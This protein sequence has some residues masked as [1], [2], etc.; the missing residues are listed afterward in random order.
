MT[1]ATLGAMPRVLMG[2]TTTGQG[3]PP[4]DQAPTGRGHPALEAVSEATKGS[5]ATKCPRKGRAHRSVQYYAVG[6]YVGQVMVDLLWRGPHEH[7]QQGG[8]VHPWRQ[9]SLLVWDPKAQARGH[10]RPHC[11]ACMA[12]GRGV[13]QYCSTRCTTTQRQPASRL[14]PGHT[15]AAK[16]KCWTTP[17][18]H[19]L[20][21]QLVRG[22]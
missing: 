18:L 1:P 10:N 8:M 9:S 5:V 16:R 3:K 22:N 7:A 14:T 4:M 21:R 2:G 15:P 17:P 12:V 19:T 6:F 20:S 11:A 13:R